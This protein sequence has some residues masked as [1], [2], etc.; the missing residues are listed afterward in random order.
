MEETGC[1]ADFIDHAY[2][3]FCDEG[4]FNEICASDYETIHSEI[5]DLCFGG[6]TNFSFSDAASFSSGGGFG[7]SGGGDGGGE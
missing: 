2:A 3:M 1:N 7:D 4:A 6:N 5:A